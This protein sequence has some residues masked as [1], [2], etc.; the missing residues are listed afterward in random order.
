MSDSEGTTVTLTF[1][2]CVENH[3]GHEQLGTK[4][5]KG[6]SVA[7]LYL[8]RDAMAEWVAQKGIPAKLQFEIVDL[9]ALCPESGV[10]AAVLVIRGLNAHT[11]QAA[12]MLRGLQWDTQM[13]SKYK[14]AV[15]EKKA[16]YNL[17]FTDV[18]RPPNL[19]EKQG[20]LYAF[21]DPAM[22]RFM[23]ALRA[24][25][26]ETLRI[27]GQPYTGVPL[28]AEGNYY[29]NGKSY[30]GLHGDKER[31]LVLAYRVGEGRPL[32]F[33]WFEPGPGHAVPCRRNGE[34]VT[35][36]IVLNDGDGYVMS[37]NAIGG[38]YGR[39][40][41]HLRHAAGDIEVLRKTQNHK[42]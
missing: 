33:W 40:V 4:I 26:T 17:C 31:R 6:P 39:N 13:W 20:R 19:Q 3:V 34:P 2:E 37:A 23:T 18:S 24:F 22:P 11:E 10:E 29:Y 9:G 32:L 28:Y 42:P 5:D 35:Q 27:D 41:Y 38:E 7:D 8:I 25:F 12:A 14:K 36:T 15:C 1:A 16:R 21:S 30:I